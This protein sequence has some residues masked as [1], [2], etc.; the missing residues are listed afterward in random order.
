MLQDA[1]ANLFKKENQQLG[2]VEINLLTASW[3]SE[4]GIFRQFTITKAD[5][6]PY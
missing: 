5:I 4:N 6:T 2:S 1:Q 3:D